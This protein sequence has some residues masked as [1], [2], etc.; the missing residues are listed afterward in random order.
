MAYRFIGKQKLLTLGSYPTV[1]SRDARG[2][3]EEAKKQLIANI[4]PSGAKL[5]TKALVVEAACNSLETVAREWFDRYSASWSSRYKASM[6]GRL[7]Y[8]FRTSVTDYGDITAGEL[9]EVLRRVEARSLITTHLS[10]QAYGRI[11]RYAA[12]TGKAEHDIAAA[13]CG[14]FASA[15]GAIMPLSPARSRGRIAPQAGRTY[16]VIFCLP[17]LVHRAPGFRLSRGTG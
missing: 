5:E 6:K 14:A 12:I 8:F 3:R 2:K 17:R 11:F 10:L 7:G 4:D 1:G 9:L 13:L 15:P 16:E